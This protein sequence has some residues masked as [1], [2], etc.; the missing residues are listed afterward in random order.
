M[1]I[2]Q[3]YCLANALARQ[4]AGLELTMG[5]RLTIIRHTCRVQSDGY[6]TDNFVVVTDPAF[7]QYDGD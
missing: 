2:L 5:G 4:R 1:S 7:Q 3:S 6:G